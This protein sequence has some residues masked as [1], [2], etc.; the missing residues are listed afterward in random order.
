[1]SWILAFPHPY[2]SLQISTRT[3][4]FIYCCHY[5]NAYY[6]AAA[7][8]S[9]QSCPTVCNP[10]DGSP[11]GFLVPGIL[12]ARIL[13]WVAISLSTAWKWKV[14]VKSLSILPIVYWIKPTLPS[15]TQSPA[16]ANSPY[17]CKRFMLLPHRT[18]LL[19]QIKMFVSHTW[20]AYSYL[21]NIFHMPN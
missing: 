4:L 12:Q 14:K 19:E 20:V 5:C 9:L 17:K 21:H 1:M 11:P 18:R 7:A 3:I 16:L 2:N 6:A 10:I 13:E 15:Q 8:K